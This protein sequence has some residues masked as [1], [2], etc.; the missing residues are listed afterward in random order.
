MAIINVRILT[1][2]SLRTCKIQMLVTL[3][4][5]TY[6]LRSTYFYFCYSVLVSIII[7]IYFCFIFTISK[8]DHTYL[9]EMYKI[10]IY[11]CTC[12]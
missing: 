8:T 9:N 10:Y 3:L 4:S 7:F 11:N 12:W 6:Y 2:I 1:S 5:F